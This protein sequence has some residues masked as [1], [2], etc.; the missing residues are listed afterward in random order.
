MRWTLAGL[1]L[2]FLLTDT[3]CQ[4]LQKN[5][6]FDYGQ[7]LNQQG[8]VKNGGQFTD[9]KNNEV[10]DI[11]YGTTIGNCGIYITR[12]GLS[13]INYK[14]KS[15]NPK[16]ILKKNKLADTVVNYKY[17][18]ERIDIN[19]QDALIFPE[20]AIEVISGNEVE[21]NFYTADNGSGIT[22]LH[23]CEQII[24]KNVYPDIDWCLQFVT[25]EAGKTMLKYN[26]I[27][28]PGGD[29]RNIK[30]HYSKN[31]PIRLNEKGDL[32]AQ[33]S[34][35]RLTEKAPVSFFSESHEPVS[36]RYKLKG[37][38][39][40]FEGPVKIFDKTVVIDPEVYWATYLSASQPGNSYQHI[41]GSDIATDANANIFVTITA[42]SK[43]P[44]ITANPGNG[45]FY[46]DYAATPYGSMI[47]MKFT[48]QG[49]LLW[50]TYFSGNGQCGGNIMTI[51]KNG[52]VYAAGKII[53]DYIQN[54]AINYPDIP[55]KDNGGYFDT[56]PKENF[57]TEFDNNGKLLWSS[58]FGGFSTY[59]QDITT[60]DEGKLYITGWADWVDFPV[61]DPGN[62]AYMEEKPVPAQ[63]VFVN[64]FDAAN[65]LLWSTHI[66]GNDYDPD[67]KIEVDKKGNIYIGSNIRSTA[68]PL[69]DAGGYFNSDLWGFTITRFNKD[70]RITWCTAIPGAF[71]FA[72]IAVD[73]DCNL[74]VLSDWGNLRKFN[75]NTE[76]VWARQYTH[77]KSYFYHR[78]LYDKFNKVLQ[79]LGQM[80]DSYWDFP[81]K[82][83]ACNG[84]F[85]YNGQGGQWT[86]ATG[87]LFMTYT[88]DG[89]VQ[90]CSLADWPVEYSA[91]KNFTVDPKGNLIYLFK[92]MFNF[93]PIPALTNPGNGA[94]FS[95]QINN[96]EQTPFLMKLITSSLDVSSA[97]TLSTSCDSNNIIDLTVICG[98]PPFKYV[99]SNG[100]DSSHVRLPAGYYSVTVTD[101]DFLTKTLQFTIPAPAGS[102][103]TF[104]AEVLNAHC[105]K[106]DGSLA[107][108]N[109]EGGKSPF[110][111]SI[112]NQPFVSSDLFAGI[113]SGSYIITV[114]DAN[115]CLA[116]DTFT[117]K[118]IPGPFDIHSVITPASCS[119]N[120]GVINVDDITGGVAP[121]TYSVNN[122][123][124]QTDAVFTGLPSSS[125]AVLIKDA[126]GCVYT[127]SLLIQQS[128]PPDS[129]TISVMPDHCLSS[130]GSIKINKVYGGSAPFNLSV[131]GVSYGSQTNIDNLKS[132]NYNLL[133]KDDKGCLLQR[134]V[135]IE[136]VPGPDKIYYKTEDAICGK[137]VG[138][139]I[140]DSVG[141][142]S[143]PY[144]FSLNSQDYQTAT[145]FS[146]VPYGT[147]TLTAK[148]NFGCQSSEA[149]DIKFIKQYALNILPHDTSVCYGQ[150][151]PF[152]LQFENPGAVK[153]IRWN[154]GEQKQSISISPLQN[155][156]VIV[157][158][159]D[160][161]G[162]IINDTAFAV[163][164]ACNTGDKCMGIPSA[165]TPNRD[166][167]NDGIGPLINGCNIQDLLFQVYNRFGQKVFETREPGKKWDGKF[168][169]EEQPEGVYVYLCSFVSGSD[170][171][172]NVKG[173]FMLIR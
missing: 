97:I 103:H 11:I 124:Y 92:E 72:D 104:A 37:Q 76:L 32:S 53:Y 169:N 133:I 56:K 18:I 118:N 146:N 137:T 27:V 95:D 110:T 69:Q 22:G 80:N 121:Y 155:S 167:L 2:L 8:F 173:S 44:F 84:S 130:A 116:K 126:F 138:S 73:E 87:P 31:A 108:K 83:T 96:M 148:D 150:T 21:Y 46:Q 30:L 141:G 19:L 153:S 77:S 165:F 43:I 62:G 144:V 107:I 152:H 74:Y 36:F 10:R 16:I 161:N 23:L 120:D 51:D 86:S 4:P 59:P 129:I 35:A 162:C 5:I 160:N 122:T 111:F 17:D 57:I 65:R 45:A 105:G 12:N 115:T 34:L 112:N 100:E 159:T 166:G 85:F 14:I 49:K 25:N 119:N 33:T 42:H 81:T 114:K 154:T 139:L 78:I 52:N 123:P 135:N 64:Q 60:D 70:R 82:N 127:D 147:H 89:E 67:S 93:N 54:S 113:D 101:A 3:Y 50:S 117:V 90:Y 15:K 88:T 24:F 71:S 13:Y 20:N 125:V 134:E 128:L 40:S 140:I 55:L 26:F 79:I 172:S 58:F 149:I 1:C 41:E 156:P 106:N 163:V 136:N 145:S 170:E 66:D 94:Y 28:R 142:E 39:V 98:K 63:L 164:K 151:I 47:I 75:E 158:V 38:T 29:V 9:E 48:S 99:W 61:V 171:K 109:I 143:S 91:Q 168:R 68:Y 132:G 157:T 7:S 6:P 102:I 131:N